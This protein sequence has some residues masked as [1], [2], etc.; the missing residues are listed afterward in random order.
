MS[1]IVWIVGASSGIGYE[2]AKVFLQNKH[3]VIVSSRTATNSTNLQNLSNSYDQNVNLV[4]VDV[5][6]TLSVQN[7]AAKAYEAY[8][9]IDLCFYNAG[10]YESMEVEGWKIG[11]FEQMAQINYLG[12]VRVTDALSSYF[13][14]QGFGSFCFNASI[15]SYF[16]LP[17]GSAYSAPKAA[18]LNF[19]E[20]IKP[21]MQTHNIEVRVVNHGFV[22]TRLTD[23][24]DF[25]MPQLLEPQEAANIIYNR[26]ENSNKFEIRFP[27]ALGAFLYLL[28]VLPY[29]LSFYFTSKA[30]K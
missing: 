10:V 25:E 11:S 24:N 13:I 8:G 1:K 28:K 5:S 15:S 3:K 9:K 23:K 20:S 29:K 2:L 27:F 12:A 22:K 14:K 18:L 26:L 17:Y 21:E 19:C 7:A 30:L 16:G 4:D 6:D